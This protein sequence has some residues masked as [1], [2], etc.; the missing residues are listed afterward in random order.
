MRKKKNALLPFDELDYSIIELLKVDSRIPAIKIAQKLGVNQRSVRK[1]IER[2][3]EMEIGRFTLALDPQV[4]GY[5]IS[6]DIF[7][8]IEEEKS[9]SIVNKLLAMPEVSYLAYGQETHEL[10]VAARF[11]NTEELYDFLRETIPSLDGV[12][13][14]KY[15]LVPRILRNIDQWMPPKDDFI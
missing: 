2:L 14:T 3:I 15:A 10:S 12:V 1:R 8:E 11:K 9:D 6:I 4:F 13:V 7:M 5:G